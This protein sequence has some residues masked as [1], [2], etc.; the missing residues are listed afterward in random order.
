MVRKINISKLSS[1]VVIVGSSLLLACPGPKDPSSDAYDKMCETLKS[2]SCPEGEDVYN[3]AL[4]GPEDVPNQS[5]DDFY[6]ELDE[7]GFQVNPECVAN[8]TSC[9]EINNLMSLDPESC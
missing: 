7:Q 3:D 4:G 5:C 8:A 2:L 9:S 6:R 1:V